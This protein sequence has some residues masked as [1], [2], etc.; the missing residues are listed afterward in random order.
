MKTKVTICDTSVLINFLKINRMDLFAKSSYTFF[1]TDHVFEEITT[2]YPEQQA[3]LDAAL[4]QNI[5]EKITVREPR[6]LEI[7]SELIRSGQLGTGE[8]AAIAVASVHDYYLAIDDNQ[9][10]KKAS[11]FLP[12]THIVRTQDLIVLMIKEQAL[13][14]EEADN[15]IQMW[16]TS[17]RFRLKIQSFSELLRCNKQA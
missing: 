14:I 11:A 3:V 2:H 4:K 8:C 17:H 6:E 12:I 13:N 10:I 15:L 1:I 5:L 16:A 9:A 7:F